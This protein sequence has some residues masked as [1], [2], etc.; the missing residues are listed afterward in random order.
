MQDHIQQLVEYMGGFFTKQLRSSV[1]HLIAD[2][3]M[4]AKYEVILFHYRHKDVIE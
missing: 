1:T 4:S 2:S 3:V